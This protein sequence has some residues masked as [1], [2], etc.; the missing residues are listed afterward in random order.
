MVSEAADYEEQKVKTKKDLLSQRN[1][2]DVIC[3]ITPETRVQIVNMKQ[4]KWISLQCDCTAP[5]FAQQRPRPCL[6]AL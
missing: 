3:S 5:F 2:G 6:R 4:N 1:V